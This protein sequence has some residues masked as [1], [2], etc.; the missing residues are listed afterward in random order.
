MV[1]SLCLIWSI[2]T[3]DYALTELSYTLLSMKTQ[4]EQEH[5][6]RLDVEMQSRGI[7]RSR[8]TANDLIKRGKVSVNGRVEMKPSKDVR[9]SDLIVVED[10]E[11]FV[12]RAG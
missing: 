3:S 5:A 10:M 4:N 7:A 9:S 8:S 6:K 12:S 11:R 1:T 2:S